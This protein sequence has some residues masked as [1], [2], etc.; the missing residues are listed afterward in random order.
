M[1]QVL[2]EKTH[3]QERQHLLVISDT[4]TESQR[5]GMSSKMNPFQHRKSGSKEF[6]KARYQWKLYLDLHLISDHKVNERATC[7]K[8]RSTEDG[9]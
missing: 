7:L 6:I 9:K 3:L 2:E 1:K 5:N 4:N 8:S